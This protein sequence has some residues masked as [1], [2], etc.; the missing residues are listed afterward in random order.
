MKHQKSTLCKGC[1]SF[2]YTKENY[3]K[4]INEPMLLSNSNLIPCVN[5]VAFLIPFNAR[6]GLTDVLTFR[7]S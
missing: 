1:F 2:R 7:D 3:I 5:L 6:S 4:H